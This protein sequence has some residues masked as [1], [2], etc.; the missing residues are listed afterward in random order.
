MK[1]TV[2]KARKPSHPFPAEAAM[3]RAAKRARAVARKF[4]TPIWIMKDGK[5][6]AVKP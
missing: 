3:R 2:K 5:I 1:A 6:V 4:G